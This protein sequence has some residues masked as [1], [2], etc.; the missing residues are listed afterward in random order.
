MPIQTVTLLW[1]K[2]TP[3]EERVLHSA[4]NVLAPEVAAILEEQLG[5]VNLAQ[6]MQ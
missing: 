6:N 1:K 4:R 2:F 3:A 5:A